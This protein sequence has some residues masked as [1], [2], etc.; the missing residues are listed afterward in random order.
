MARAAGS[1][2]IESYCASKA[3]ARSPARL[4]PTSQELIRRRATG[5]VYQWHWQ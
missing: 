3:L 5:P 4:G 1:C 2:I